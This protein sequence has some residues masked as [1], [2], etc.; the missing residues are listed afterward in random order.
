MKNNTI[1]KIAALLVLATAQCAESKTYF[2]EDFKQYAATAPLCNPAMSIMLGNDPIWSQTADATCAA[3]TGGAFFKD[4]QPE[5]A[6]EELK[7][8]QVLFSFRFNDATSKRLRTVLRFSQGAKVSE[9]RIDFEGGRVSVSAPGLSPAVNTAANFALPLPKGIWNDCVISV[10]GGKMRIWVSELRLL[11]PAIELSIPDHKFVG[12]NFEV[13]QGAPF[14]ICDIEVRDPGS[15]DDNDVARLLPAPRLIDEASFKSGGEHVVPVGGRCGATLRAG[16][17]SATATLVMDWDDGT[18]T[19]AKFGTAG[20][21]GKRREIVNGEATMVDADLA[22]AYIRVDG[23]G[24]GRDTLNVYVRPLLRRYHTSYS[25]T[26]AYHDIVRDWDKLPPASGHPLRVEARSNA[27]GTD[28]YLD[29]SLAASYAG[30]KL[31]GMKFVLTSVA[32]ISEIFSQDVNFDGNRYLP[33]DISA[34]GMAKSF[35]G[36]AHSLAK[37]LGEVHGIPIIVAGGDGSGDVGLA[38]EGQGNWALEVDEYTARSPFDGLLT[39]LHFSVP[40]GVPYT[41]AWVL[42]A[43]DPDTAKDP[44]LTTRLAHYVENGGGNNRIADT[45]TVLPRVGET[46]E[47]GVVQVGNVN[48][49]GRSVPLLLVEVPLNGGKILDLMMKESRMDFEFIG[50]LWENFEQIDNSSKPDPKSTSAVQIFGV[51][52]ERGKVGLNM[53]Q[54]QPANIFQGDEK[55]ETTAVLG[56]FAPASGRLVWDINDVAGTRV[57]GGAVP[58]KFTKAGE[59]QRVV[60]PL[61]TAEA[62]WYGLDVRIEDE[63]GRT[64]MEHPGAFARLSQDTRKAHYDSPFG[65]WWFDGAHLTPSDLA[66]A[67][68]VMEKA[69]IRAVAWTKQPAAALDGYRLFKDQVNMPFSFS[70]FGTKEDMAR[71]AANPG[72]KTAAVYARKKTEFDQIL[73]ANPHLREVL[74]FHE[75]GPGNDVPPE[76]LGVNYTPETARTQNEKR[77]A[78]LVNL[79]GPFFRTY[80]PNIKTVL[81]NNS[82]SAANVAAVFRHGGKPEYVDYIGIEAPSQVY[83]PEKLQEWALQGQ[84]IAMDTA[85]RI[86]GR[87]IPATGC[88]EFTYRSERD[89]GKLQHAEWYARDVLISLSH[90]F[91]RIGPGILFDT[92]NAYYNGLW[93]GSGLLERAPAGYPKP[94]YV[95]YAVLTDVMDQVSVDRQIPTGSKAVYAVSFKRKDGKYATA[96]WSARGEV[97]FELDFG[98]ATEV[99]TVAMFGSRA[100]KQANGG[101][102]SVQAGTSPAYVL[103][104]RPVNTATITGRSFSKDERRAEASAPVMTFNDASEAAVVAGTRFDT[105]IV[106]PVQLPVRKAGSFDLSS[107]Q[108]DEKGACVELTLKT[109]GTGD[110]NKYITEYA[111]IKLAT[112]AKVDGRPV[113]FGVTVRGNSNWGRVLVE[114]ED[115]N[116]EVWRSL[117]TGGWGCDV[118]DWP[119]NAAVNF[120]G[121]N[122][123]SHPLAQTSLFNDHSPGPVMEQWVSDGGDK[124]VDFPIS[125]TGLIVEMNRSPLVLTDFQDAEPSVRIKDIRALYESAVPQQGQFVSIK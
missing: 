50:K 55:P 42:C 78:D 49:G 114:F 65:V 102:L 57:G 82:C 73:A 14:S 86:G 10:G 61:G 77:Y 62:G 76:V 85:E 123:V 5:H 64:V 36:A 67:G 19:S 4:F 124:V 84:H 40:G 38:R 104:S 16:A 109:D 103:S 68:P 92:Q 72:E 97:D 58:F 70:D 23:L 60:I 12:L 105:P 89:M 48:A 120:D 80:Y 75:S 100:L 94:A 118:L 106:F 31:K 96:L 43:V 125:V 47:E 18:Q 99:E 81:G 22:D 13:V 113:G 116:G 6:P 107:V 32:S 59:S 3:T 90:N 29:G 63:A 108:D 88:Y 9:C 112:P 2:K 1:I 83:I 28:V 34:L 115:A 66:F 98:S 79:V 44:V 117:G 110:L 39:E 11:K 35:A 33:L 41:R 26:D 7:E 45:I 56:S 15:L 20:V 24:S 51:T 69:G 21:T 54:T 37:G 74:V 25:F 119:G 27:G 101:K 111:V 91:T 95:A 30:K 71:E 121:W 53:E 52:L 93:G 87:R 8:Y 17:G 46:L 122:M